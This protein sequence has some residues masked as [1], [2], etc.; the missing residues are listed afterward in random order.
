MAQADPY[1]LAAFESGP[2]NIFRESFYYFLKGLE[3]I[4]LVKFDTEMPKNKS[5]ENDN[6]EFTE[7]LWK[8]ASEHNTTKEIVFLK[9]GFYNA[10]F[11]TSKRETILID[12]KDRIANKKDVDAILAYG[13]II[14]KTWIQSNPPVPTLVMVSI[15]PVADTTI[16]S[17]Y[18]SGNDMVTVLIYDGFQKAQIEYYYN[19]L[20]F[21][22]LG[23][24]FENTIESRAFSRMSGIL[25]FLRDN[26][27][28][29]KTCYSN[30]IDTQ[31]ERE[32]SILSCVNKLS[33]EV[34]AIYMT[35]HK[36]YSNRVA[37]EIT[38]I[39]RDSKTATFF[40][41]GHEYV[42]RGF[43]MSYFAEHYLEESGL[44]MAKR[45]Q[46]IMNGK[47]PRELSQVYQFKNVVGC[48]NKETATI[49]GVDISNEKC[50]Y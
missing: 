10:N 15:D 11:D 27:I 7:E 16:K 33:K 43:L 32:R 24:I 6:G 37:D 21:T 26:N 2:V 34:E 47:K 31:Q 5:D 28:T 50:V 44:E 45:L 22:S 4:N 49:L 35:V 8:W 9:D 14:V 39:T 46:Q 36:G 40:D 20:K 38:K 12:L 3:Q 19:K 1:R 23:L 41:F 13:I 18:D 30:E 29:I 17:K 42:K 48:Y 25:K